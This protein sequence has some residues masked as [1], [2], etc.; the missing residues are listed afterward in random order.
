M[1]LFFTITKLKT[2]KTFCVPFTMDSSLEE[3]GTYA[4]SYTPVHLMSLDPVELLWLTEKEK[5][6]TYT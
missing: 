2:N 3:L 5:R 1:V 6:L 4:L